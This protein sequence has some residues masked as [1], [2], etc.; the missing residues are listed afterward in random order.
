[1]I[2]LII[3]DKQTRKQYSLSPFTHLHL[4]R[5]LILY[6]HTVFNMAAIDRRCNVVM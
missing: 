3:A 2:F 1:M 4:S 6:M 5:P